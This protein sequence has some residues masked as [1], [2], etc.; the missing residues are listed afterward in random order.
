MTYLVLPYKGSTTVC[1]ESCKERRISQTFCDFIA[2]QH[3]Q[4][5]LAA[6]HSFLVFAIPIAATMHK[7]PICTT[8]FSLLLRL[9]FRPE[10]SCSGSQS[11]ERPG[12]LN[13]CGRSS[14][15]SSSNLKFQSSKRAL[16]W[17]WQWQ[18]Y[19][20]RFWHFRKQTKSIQCP[21][22]QSATL[23]T[24]LSLSVSSI[25]EIDGFLNSVLIEN[26]INFHLSLVS[27]L[28]FSGNLF[29]KVCKIITPYI[30]NIFIRECNFNFIGEL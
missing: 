17:Y 16:S 26:H 21:V 29:P 7:F 4:H 3:L 2:A 27:S 9:C 8:C 25:S 22:F 11:L 20:L 12:L 13:N 28:S 30:L 15:Y 6:I 23:N 18:R 5:S 1:R 10:I 14:Q 19:Y 24:K